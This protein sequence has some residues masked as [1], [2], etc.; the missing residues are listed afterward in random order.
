MSADKTFSFDKTGAVESVDNLRL[1]EVIQRG[2]AKRYAE[3]KGR[4]ARWAEKGKVENQHPASKRNESRR[5]S[6]N[7]LHS[8]A[9]SSAKETKTKALELVEVA[10]SVQEHSLRMISDRLASET[11]NAENDLAKVRSFSRKW[12]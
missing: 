6:Q 8:K 12:R 1:E 3:E 2:G 9:A 10:G 4:E 5:K 11:K 7:R